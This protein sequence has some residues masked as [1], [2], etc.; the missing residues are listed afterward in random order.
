MAS[1]RRQGARAEQRAKSLLK[2][3]G[4]K[5]EDSQV[6]GHVHVDGKNQEFPVRADFLVS[7]KGRTF[8]AEC[9]GGAVSGSVA[10]I[11]TRRQLLEYTYAFSVQGVLLVNTVERKV[12]RIEFRQTYRVPSSD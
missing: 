1:H 4:Y 2:A 5:M 3:Q 10:N 7:K 12:M 11:A 8:I 6:T 9:K